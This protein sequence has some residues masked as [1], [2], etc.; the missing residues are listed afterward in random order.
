MAQGGRLGVEAGRAVAAA[1]DARLGDDAVI[2]R[3]VERGA[4]GPDV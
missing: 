1:E 3:A 2:V 4:Q